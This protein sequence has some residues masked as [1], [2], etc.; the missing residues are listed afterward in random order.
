MDR[1]LF[2]TKDGGYLRLE[3]QTRVNDAASEAA[4]RPV[5]D[6]VLFGGVTNPNSRDEATRIIERHK[7]DGSIWHDGDWSQRFADHIEQFKRTGEAEAVGT[8]LRSWPAMDAR[9]A[10]DLAAL[11]IY[12]I[13][14][15]AGLSDTGLGRI[16]MGARELQAKAKAF[17]AAAKDSAE[18]P[19]L[20]AENERLRGDVARLQAQVMELAA[21][22]QAISDKQQEAA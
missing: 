5:H 16:G 11:R 15:L 12:T 18:A 2:K 10:A 7:P 22:L 4:G 14:D 1:P 6:K 19:R 8:P 9:Q 17:L 21:R 20:A 13:E 3:W